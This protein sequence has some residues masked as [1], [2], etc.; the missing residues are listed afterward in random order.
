MDKAELHL[1]DDTKKVLIETTPK[2]AAPVYMVDVNHKNYQTS[3][4]VVSD[5]HLAQRIALLR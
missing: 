4:T 1:G 5:K 3:N 2:D